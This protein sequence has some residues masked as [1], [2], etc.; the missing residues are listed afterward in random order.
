MMMTVMMMVVVTMMVLLCHGIGAAQTPH[1]LIH[2]GVMWRWLHL[3]GA[4]CGVCL[5]ARAPPV[6]LHTEIG[7][8]N[9]HLL[10]CLFLM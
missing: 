3:Q 4:L 1:G 8:N 5:V 7:Y 2:V 6:G 9:V 10:I